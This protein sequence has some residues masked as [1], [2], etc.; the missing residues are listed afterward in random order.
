M[1]S[2]ITQLWNNLSWSIDTDSRPEV[3]LCDLRC[4]LHCY[5]GDHFRPD[6]SKCRCCL[7][8]N[9]SFESER[10]MTADWT[11]LT[12]RWWLFDTPNLTISQILADQNEH[13]L[14]TR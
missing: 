2:I 1:R 14:N 6:G 12:T 11:S 3:H 8:R 7:Q 9:A 10:A 5:V 13:R 4:K